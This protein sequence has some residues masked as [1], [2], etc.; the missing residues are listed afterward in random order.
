MNLTSNT[1]SASIYLTM[2]NKEKTKIDKNEYLKI[3]KTNR[4]EL[5]SIFNNI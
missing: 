2:V 4:N 5:K 3:K 1:S